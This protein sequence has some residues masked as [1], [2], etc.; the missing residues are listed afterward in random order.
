MSNLTQWRID[1]VWE[2]TDG[3]CHDC[4]VIELSGGYRLSEHDYNEGFL[5]RREAKGRRLLNAL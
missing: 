4:L 2:L 3:S 5:A 1:Q